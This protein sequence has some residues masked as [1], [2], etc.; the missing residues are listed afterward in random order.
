MES[1]TIPQVPVLATPI[2]TVYLPLIQ[3]S[4]DDRVVVAAAL[5]SSFQRR[6]LTANIAVSK[7]MSIILTCIP[8]LTKYLIDAKAPVHVKRLDTGKMIESLTEGHHPNGQD[9]DEWAFTGLVPESMAVSNPQALYAAAAVAF[10]TY[11]K[12]AG[13]G[14]QNAYEVAR[15]NSLIGK[16]KL[17][18]SEIFLFPG[19]THGPDL[20]ALDQVNAGFG[21]FPQLRYLLTCFFIGLD[22]S[23]MFSPPNVDP[24]RVMFALLKNVGMT[25]LGAVTNL[26]RSRPWTAK[27]PELI[28][29]YQIFAR[30]LAKFQEVPVDLRPYHRLLVDQSQYL[31]LTSEIRPL[32][33]VAGYYYEEVEKTFRDYVY[34][35]DRY[36]DL[37][38]RVASRDPDVPINT[39]MADL[40]ALLG[41]QDVDPRPI[42]LETPPSTT[43]PIL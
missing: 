3:S 16:Y 34:N 35:K 10:M 5:I 14:A 15:P 43:V 22:R 4:E 40:V 36:E 38:R 7:M 6:S 30:D 2:L 31:F 17:D 21:L 8:E 23:R 41:I 37:I 28:P 13:E 12:P 9:D 20:E 39:G 26:L 33:A 42:P 11:A 27:L 19:G 32:I 18:D 25:H 1:F 24:F 29:Y